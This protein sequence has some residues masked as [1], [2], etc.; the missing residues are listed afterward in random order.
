M[1]LSRLIPFA[2]ACALAAPALAQPATTPLPEATTPAQAQAQY[3]QGYNGPR[4]PDATGGNPGTTALNG[5]A[6]QQSAGARVDDATAQG[7]YAADMAAYHSALIANHREAMRDQ[8]HYDHQQRAYADAMAAWRMQVE[9]CRKRS[10]Y[11]CKAPAPD[12]ADYY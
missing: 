6:L 10:N 1:M 3:D 7:Q 8:A 5:Q 9:D 2:L 12:P 4:S 11:A